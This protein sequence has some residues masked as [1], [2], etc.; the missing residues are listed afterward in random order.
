MVENGLAL[1]K[2]F[3]RVSTVILVRFSQSTPDVDG[4]AHVIPHVAY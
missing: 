2:R 4:I 3:Q 1:R